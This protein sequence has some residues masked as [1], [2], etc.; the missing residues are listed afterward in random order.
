MHAYYS[1]PIEQEHRKYL[2]FIWRSKLDQYTCFPNGLPSAPSLFTK[3]LKPCCAHLRCLGYIVSGYIDDTY[4]QQQLFND[5]LHSLNACGG[6]FACL[7]L[8]THPEKSLDIP[9]Q[10]ATVLGFIINSLDMTFPYDWKEDKFARALSQNS[11]SNQTIQDFARFTGKLVSSFP[12]VAHG[13][14][15]YL[16]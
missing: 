11:E 6:F 7:G 15:F 4:L 2:C 14:L 8:L 5:A 9:S 10:I 3:P 16:D 1:V 13:P 12:G